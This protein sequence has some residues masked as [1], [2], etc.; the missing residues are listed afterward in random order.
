MSNRM[1]IIWIMLNLT[2]IYSFLVLIL[3]SM[4][5]KYNDLNTFIEEFKQAIMV[6]NLIAI[7][8]FFEV[9]YISIFK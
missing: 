4:R 3:A 7:A 5:F 9:I 1:P 6:I 2:D 8:Q